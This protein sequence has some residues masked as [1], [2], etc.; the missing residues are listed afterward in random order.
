MPLA[1]PT[2]RDFLVAAASVAGI[3]SAAIL[4]PLIAQMNPD[5]AAIAA[6]AVVAGN[7]LGLL[8]TSLKLLGPSGVLGQ[9]A[10]GQGRPIPARTLRFR[11][12]R[13]IASMN[14]MRTGCLL[15]QRIIK[16]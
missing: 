7:G 4:V 13:T 3:R 14:T 11:Q 16:R 10:L 6:G 15:K 9:S 8:N 1:E 2:R 12:R 5:F